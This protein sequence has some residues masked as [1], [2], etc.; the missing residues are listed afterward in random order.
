MI[1]DSLMHKMSSR[2]PGNAC[3][4]AQSLSVRRLLELDTGSLAIWTGRL[5][6]V[7]VTLGKSK[8]VFDP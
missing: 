1:C 4:L 5:W 7:A 8:I 6:R 3:A 2:E